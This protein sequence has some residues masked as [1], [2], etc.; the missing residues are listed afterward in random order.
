MFNQFL[1]P[2]SS[3]RTQA[4]LPAQVK[5]QVIHTLVGDPATQQDI[6][7]HQQVIH[8]ENIDTS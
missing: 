1:V 2:S 5:H 6:H 4:I 8:N 7:D 3:Q